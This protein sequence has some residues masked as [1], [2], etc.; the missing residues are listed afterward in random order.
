MAADT[1]KAMAMDAGD[2]V[3][4]MDTCIKVA[5]STEATEERM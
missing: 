3:T 2:G 4:D 1:P 5:I